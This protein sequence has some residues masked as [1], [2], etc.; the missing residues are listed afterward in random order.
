LEGAPVGREEGTRVG[1]KEGDFVGINEGV[2]DGNSEGFEDGSTVG[3][4]EG[5]DDGIKEGLPDGSRL[6]SVLGDK[7]GVRDGC[8][9]GMALGIAVGLNVELLDGI[10]E[11]WLEI[12]EANPA[13]VSIAIAPIRAP[14]LITARHCSEDRERINAMNDMF[15]VIFIALRW[16]DSFDWDNRRV[17]L[18]LHTFRSLHLDLIS[19]GVTIWR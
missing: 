5:W 8:I 16:F 3:I 17:V 2:E 12:A 14:P 9:D 15:F 11:G 19:F 1:I 7:E 10:D 4:E 18:S 13:T 6:G